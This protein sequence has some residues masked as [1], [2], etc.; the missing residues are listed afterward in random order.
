MAKIAHVPM[1]RVW[2]EDECEGLF[3]NENGAYEL[4]EQ[5]RYEKWGCIYIE[6]IQVMMVRQSR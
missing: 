3:A 2:H 1:W 4:A 6:V 5:L